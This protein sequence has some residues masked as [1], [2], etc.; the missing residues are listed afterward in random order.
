MF[1]LDK[2]S[3]SLRLRLVTFVHLGHSLLMAQ[4]KWCRAHT[5]YVELAGL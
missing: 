4:P 3:R 2:L 1:G 5:W